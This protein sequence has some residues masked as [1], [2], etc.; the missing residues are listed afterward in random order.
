MWK[1]I[2]AAIGT[3]AIVVGGIDWLVGALVSH[4][5]FLLVSGI[6]ALVFAEILHLW[7]K[8]WQ[9][10][11]LPMTTLT[12]AIFG[13]ADICV[14]GIHDVLI[15]PDKWPIQQWNPNAMS[16]SKVWIIIGIIVALGL[17]CLIVQKFLHYC[18]GQPQ[19]QK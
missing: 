11:I 13:T 17:A 14:A 7:Q 16:G 18:F 6:V 15:P 9:K 1:Y 2:L 3:L 8:S 10:F 4:S 5:R 19:S 12:V